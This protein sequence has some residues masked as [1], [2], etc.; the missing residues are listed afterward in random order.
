MLW[1]ARVMVTSLRRNYQFAWGIGSNKTRQ[2]LNFRSSTFY[3]NIGEQF[4]YEHCNENQ[5]SDYKY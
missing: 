4:S 5:N 1:Q 2:E 3:I